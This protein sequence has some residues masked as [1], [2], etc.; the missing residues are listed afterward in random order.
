LVAGCSQDNEFVPAT[1]WHQ[2]EGGSIA[3]QR[4]PP[5]NVTAPYPSLGT[6]P[7]KPVTIDAATRGRIANALVA[8]RANAEYTN[9]LAPLPAAPPAK[10]APPGPPASAP[11]GDS[12]MSA[13]L[14]AA[15]A[16]PQPAPRRAPVAA[17]AATPLPAPGASPATPAAG[18]A[19]GAADAAAPMP[20][21]PA[22]P[23]QIPSIGGVRA[24]VPTP[25]P[26]TPPVV[27]P[28][29][30]VVPGAPV[31]IA[32]AAGSA[33]MP[34]EA[35]KA[36]TSLAA[37]RGVGSI[38]ITGYGEAT[39]SDPATQ[40]AAMPLAWGRAESIARALLVAGVPS[41]SL[42]V[43]SQATGHGGVARIVE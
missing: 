30:P 23:P 9:S 13:S 35:V 39:S 11:S 4:P 22:A 6:V 15:S 14:A 1:W 31:T 7:T 3:Q 40:S 36:L 29:A 34:P 33:T 43:T 8:D 38:A 24:T 5:P 32:F 2:L 18:T 42:R 12:G 26:P 17:V 27:T 16:P 25:P 37:R 41:K 21:I 20:P 28:P 10:T 19:A